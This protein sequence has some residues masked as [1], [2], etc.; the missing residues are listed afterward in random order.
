MWELGVVVSS[1]KEAKE[2]ILGFPPC[3][4]PEKTVSVRHSETVQFQELQVLISVSFF[5]RFS[6]WMKMS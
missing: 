5:W 2:K 6:G 1:K 3:P 4:G